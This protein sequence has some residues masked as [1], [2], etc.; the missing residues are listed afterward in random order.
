[1]SDLDKI[2]IYVPEETAR[3]LESDAEMFEFF[4]KDGRTVNRNRFLNALLNGYDAQYSAEYRRTY[5]AI[6]TQLDSPGLS[7]NEKERLADRIQKEVFLPPVRRR[8]GKH[9]PKFSLK[10]TN[11]TEN[12]ILRIRQDAATRDYLSQY[13][14]RMLMSY[15]QKSFPEREQILFRETYDFLREACAA[16][17]PVLFSTTLNKTAIHEVV[18]Y[19]LA[20]GKEEMFNYLVCQETQEPGAL[21]HARS[22]RLCRIVA[23]AYSSHSLSL[24]D[25]NI[26]CMDRMISQGPQ[27]VIR[28][29]EESCV[30][31]TEQGVKTYTLIYYG[32]PKYDRI[33]KHGDCYDYYFSASPEQLFLYFRRFPVD[34]AI[35]IR[36][37]RLRKSILSFHQ[38][39]VSAYNRY[40]RS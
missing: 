13:L 4:K 34:D 2:N 29:E 9:P 20:T 25:N 18:P 22:Y 8:K 31:L 30:R 15:A 28:K 26:R 6:L 39:V 40:F 17:R 24:T 11:I 12:I 21:P 1:M 16:R 27:Y 32:R 23:P 36:P 14:C 5:E 19:A 37:V 38:G 7:Q 3:I 33:E 35:V 10:P